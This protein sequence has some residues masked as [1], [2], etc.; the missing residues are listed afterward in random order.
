MRIIATSMLIVAAIIFIICH[1][2]QRY[3]DWVWLASYGQPP[4]PAW[5]AAWPTGSR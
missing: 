2:L 3:Y 1:I 4:K 5:S